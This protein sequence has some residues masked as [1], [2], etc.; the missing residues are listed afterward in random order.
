MSKVYHDKDQGFEPDRYGIPGITQQ[1]PY[2]TATPSPVS[3]KSYG[4]PNVQT[5]KTVRPVIYCFTTPDNHTNDGWCKIGYTD[6]QTAD[7]RIQQE[8]YTTNT[9]CKKE[10][11]MPA[12]FD[13]YQPFT[14][15]D[16]HLYLQKLGIQRQTSVYGNGRKTEFFKIT[17][18]K[19]KDYLIRF[20][21]MILPETHQQEYTLRAEQKSAVDLMLSYIAAAENK[22]VLLN[23]KP[24]FGKTLT[25]YDYCKQ[26]KFTKIL[27]ITNRPVIASSWY[28]DYVKFLGTDDYVFVSNCRAVQNE[29]YCV[30][31]EEYVTQMSQNPQRR[32]IEFISLQDLKGSKWFGGHFDKL[33]EVADLEWDVLVVDESHEGVDTSK[34]NTVFRHIKRGETIYLSGT[35]FKQI[36]S[37][38]FTKEAIFN[39]TYPQE[40]EAKM[41]WDSEEDEVNP[42]A[43]LPQ[44]NLYTYR[45]S[46]MFIDEDR[47]NADIVRDKFFNLNEFFKTTESG[48]FVYDADVDQ[49]LNIITM[50]EKYPLGSESTRS[51]IKH[52]LWLMERV[53]G[54]KALARKLKNHPAFKDYHIVVAAG[55]GKIEDGDTVDDAFLKVKDAIAKYDRTITISVGQLTTGV[56]IPEWSAVFM[57]CNVASASLYIQAAF[58]AQN[59]C[60]I[61]DDNGTFV[62]KEN[63]YI[64][65]FDPARTLDIM[66]QFANNLYTET[67][68]GRGDAQQRSQNID[69]LMRYFPIYGEDDDGVLVSYRPEDV[70]L[71]PSKIQSRE[72]VK[73]GFMCNFLFQNV[74][75][76][77]GDPKAM[78]ILDDVNDIKNKPRT[79]PSAGTVSYDD[80][81]NAK[82]KEENVAVA[83]QTAQSQVAAAITDNDTQAAAGALRG[84]VA[85]SNTFLDNLRGMQN[86]ASPE[87]KKR[88]D[89]A[90]TEFANERAQKVAQV[91]S[92][93][94]SSTTNTGIINTKKVEQDLVR[95]YTEQVRQLKADHD[96]EDE[97]LRVEFDA[98]RAHALS[99]EAVK[100]V[101][102]EYTEAQQMQAWEFECAITALENTFK[103]TIVAD[104]VRDLQTKEQD[105]I[106]K[107]AENNYAFPK[108]K[109]FA[110]SIPAFLM[111]YGTPETTCDKFGLIIPPAIFKEMT[112]IELDDY[113]YFIDNQYFNEVVF[114][115]AIKEFFSLRTK[116][117]D[118]FDDAQEEDIFDYIPPQKTNQIY[119]PKRVVKMM[120]D[121]LEKENPGCFDDP[122]KTFAD[123]YMKSGLYITEI[124]KRLYRS[125][126]MKNCIPDDAERLRH[127]FAHQ[128]YG[129]APTEILYKITTNFILGFSD[130]IE[131]PEH[132]IRCFDMTPIANS[133]NLEEEL[134]RVF[135]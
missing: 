106:N 14:D 20:R 135:Q 10:W 1:Y 108:L 128:V 131:I 132:H 111:A 117:A 86:P 48:K 53:D 127:I 7:E 45:L 16:F 75:R 65:D 105:K 72:V 76:I 38:R 24:R 133:E 3:T 22:E 89:D 71:I 41:T 84:Q 118:Y 13:D 15:H 96:I 12:I 64:F 73:H 63:A 54:A 42:Y 21:S 113:M 79:A 66:E 52:S 123:L 50:I 67:A 116:L 83:T 122:N 34:S 97:R 11:E 44:L 81:G 92:S 125:E 98:K 104:A 37:E 88:T 9:F 130:S 62:R 61:Q 121:I 68:A 43:E 4:K 39:W 46:D 124:V 100:Q 82:P 5:N 56:T 17:P 91:I 80:T 114:N 23:A 28:S 103:T 29:P 55:D 8:S 49:F 101:V 57:L 60:L 119:T 47:M 107:N 95:S 18:Q 32:L 58:R 120:V 85:P 69:K 19:A 51:Q 40:Q 78:N 74:G 2:N 25:V 33:K 99:T 112:G 110:R 93:A 87:N 59:P 35:P 70:I 115:D 36:A 129:L 77:F 6:K 27:I 90:A 102:V 30:N 94:L 109:A 134:R 31:R 126:A 26:R